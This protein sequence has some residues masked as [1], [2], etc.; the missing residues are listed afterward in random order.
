VV[1]TFT[2]GFIHLIGIVAAIGA[3]VW[4]LEGITAGTPARTVSILIYG[5][6]LVSM[7]AASAAYSLS[8]PGP[9]K[10]R[11][12]RLDHA[13]IFV[14]IAGTY[15]PICLLALQPRLGIPLFAVLWGLAG[16]GVGLKLA[17][18]PRVERL[19]LVM[20]LGMGWVLLAVIRSL[21][22]ALTGEELTLLL[23]G[24]VVYSLGT[25]FHTRTS[26]PFH[27][28][29]WHTMVL[30]AAGLHFTAMAQLFMRT[31]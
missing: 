7:L 30:I 9:V 8:S 28:A 11:F 25:V 1:E 10:R 12:R 31:A 15:T 24:G 3:V 22:V 16:A 20:Y 21:V 6:G 27:N 17:F 2:D 19:S 5:L 14:M 13:M 18:A 23:A 26:V 4:L 29:I